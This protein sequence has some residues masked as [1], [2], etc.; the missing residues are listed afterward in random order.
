MKITSKGPFWTNKKSFSNGP[1]GPTMKI[2][3]K[4]PFWTN[5]E[6]YFKLPILAQQWRLHQMAHVSPTMKNISIGPYCPNKWTCNTRLLLFGAMLSWYHNLPNKM[7]NQST[8][9]S[10]NIYIKLVLWEVMWYFLHSVCLFF[11]FFDLKWI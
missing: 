6:E 7:V 1:F 10:M 5:N 8:N 4:G 3:S 2:A 9:Q 11:L